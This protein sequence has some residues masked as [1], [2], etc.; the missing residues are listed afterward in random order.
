MSLAAA[1]PRDWRCVILSPDN[2]HPMHAI[3]F[4]NNTDLSRVVDQKGVRL[5]YVQLACQTRRRKRRNIVGGEKYLFFC[6]GE[7]DQGR[8]NRR[9]MREILGDLTNIQ[10]Y[11]RVQQYCNQQCQEYASKETL[12]LAWQYQIYSTI[13]T[14]SGACIQQF[15]KFLF[16]DTLML[17]YLGLGYVRTEDLHNIQYIQQYRHLE[18]QGALRAPTSSLRPFEPP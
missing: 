10:Q 17:A 4:I 15:Q 18:V 3:N 11:E 12:M 13:Q 2:I 5:Y 14:I 8:K 7:E 1:I 6:S 9:K 16:T